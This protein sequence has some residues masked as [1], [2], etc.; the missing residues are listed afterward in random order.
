VVFRTGFRPAEK[1]MDC[2]SCVPRFRRTEMS[3]EPEA[4]LERDYISWRDKG[5]GRQPALPATWMATRV[6]AACTCSSHRLNSG[7]KDW[8]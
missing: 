4:E 6:E 8:D 5:R 1:G 3:T 2:S 7:R